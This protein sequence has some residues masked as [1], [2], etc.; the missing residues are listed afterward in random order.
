MFKF[1]DIL[2][3][4]LTRDAVKNLAKKIG[5]SD[6]ETELAIE[7]VNTLVLAFLSKKTI[8]LQNATTLAKV[9]DRNHDGAIAD[10]IKT[11]VKNLAQGKIDAEEGIEIVEDIFTDHRQEVLQL[12]CSA[13]G[14]TANAATTVLLAITPLVVKT[15]V[16]EQKK[17]NWTLKDLGSKLGDGAK[18]ANNQLSNKLLQ[19]LDKDNN[20]KIA[21]DLWRSTKGLFQ[22][23]VA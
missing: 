3:N 14:L 9:L 22:K 21:D 20:G 17:G 6:K 18:M 11:F 15:V 19:I 2:K 1:T 16:D 10:D 8:L 4:Y 23:V 5:A 12:V 13:T 7:T